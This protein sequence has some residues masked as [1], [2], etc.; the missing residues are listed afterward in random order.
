MSDTVKDLLEQAARD[1][2]Q[3]HSPERQAEA[4]MQSGFTRIHGNEAG[5][6]DSQVQSP[7]GAQ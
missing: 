6:S 4:R 3:H 5:G 2:A 1:Y 7:G